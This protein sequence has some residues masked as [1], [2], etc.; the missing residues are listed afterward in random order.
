MKFTFEE[1]ATDEERTEDDPD[2]RKLV[3]VSGGGRA[4][5]LPLAGIFIDADRNFAYELEDELNL[6]PAPDL[7][8][9]IPDDEADMRAL[10]RMYE[11][12]PQIL[13]KFLASIGL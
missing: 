1:D 9:D 3:T 8:D 7:L 11:R 5:A 13:A 2:R 4:V 6:M 12:N 10:R